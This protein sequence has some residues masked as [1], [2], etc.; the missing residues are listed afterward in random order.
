MNKRTKGSNPCTRTNQHVGELFARLF[1]YGEGASLQPDR[2]QRA[3]LDSLGYPLG[4]DPYFAALEGSLIFEN[5]NAEMELREM[6]VWRGSNRVLSISEIPDQ[7]K[8]D[9]KRNIH[10]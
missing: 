10:R 9:M 4:A 7:A 2:D 8:E 5:S 1:Q 6:R 3:L